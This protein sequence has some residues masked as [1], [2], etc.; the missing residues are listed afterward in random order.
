[1]TMRERNLAVIVNEVFLDP[2]L[3]SLSVI[4]YQDQNQGQDLHLEGHHV[5]IQ[6]PII[7]LALKGINL[8]RLKN[9]FFSL[10]YILY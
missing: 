9:Q 8:T 2:N 10:I 3:L 6:I 1:M 5:S 4:L 7:L